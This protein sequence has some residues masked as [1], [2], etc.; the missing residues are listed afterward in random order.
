[1][2]RRDKML[3][4]FRATHNT[5]DW[6]KYKSL[7]NSVKFNLRN[8]EFNYIRTQIEHCK[9][10]PRSTWKV[11]KSCIPTKESTNAG[12]QKGHSRIAE[13]FNTYFTAVKVKEPA[14]EDGISITLSDAS[15]TYKYTTSEEMFTLRDVTPNEV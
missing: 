3:K 5:D 13:E 1:M 6:V 9:G 14:E 7:R 15:T 12:Y 11:I 4:V 8:A 2:N 10:N